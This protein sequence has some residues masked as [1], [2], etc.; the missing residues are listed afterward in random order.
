M[1]MLIAL[2][3]F[4]LSQI[5]A[6]APSLRVG[7]EL[8]YPPFET[9]CNDG[10]PC[11]ISVDIAMALGKSLDRPVKFENIPFVGLIPSLKNGSI[12]TIISSLTITEQRRKAI[13]FSDPYATI[14]L[15]LLLNIN[16]TIFDI[17]QANTKGIII[18]VKAGTSGE[19]YASQH[20]QNATVRN[21][22]KESSCVLE[23][24]QGKADAFIYDQLSVYTNW[25]KNP[26]T[27]KVNLTAFQ[28]EHW[29]FGIRKGN[30]ELAN[31]INQFIKKFREENKFDKLAD[32]Y[33]P[34]QKKA[35][36][37]MGV[38]FVF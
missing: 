26:T 4:H 2:L 21:L 28:K 29:A 38:P 37:E 23:V 5:S 3:F 16:S 25:K 6:D 8:S 33:L 19:L 13:D 32:K 14:G 34:D 15:C 35:F 24:I 27:T 36:Q 20:L 11:G 31:Q 12:D 10:K 22:D 7:M 9:I 30:Q 18:V 1:K 17:E